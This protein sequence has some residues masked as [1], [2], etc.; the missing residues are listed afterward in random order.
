MFLYASRNRQERAR[1]CDGAGGRT[2]TGKGLP[3]VD[4]ESTASTNSATP[5]ER[6]CNLASP[7]TFWQD[8]SRI[9]P[10]REIHPSYSAQFDAE[11]SCASTRQETESSHSGHKTIKR[12]SGSSSISS[13]NTLR[14]LRQCTRPQA[15]HALG[16]ACRNRKPHAGHSWVSTSSPSSA[17]PRKH[18]FMAAFSDIC[19]ISV[20]PETIKL[21][22]SFLEG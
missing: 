16:C 21:A 14:Q 13:R 8:A 9:F 20:E 10:I 15:V 6:A 7:H 22:S 18:A 1:G 3:P 11:T 5:A 17:S 2:R 4:F 19:Y 12:P